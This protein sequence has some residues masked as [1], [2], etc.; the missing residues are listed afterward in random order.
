MR[1]SQGVRSSDKRRSS[2]PAFTS[3]RRTLCSV[4]PAEAA[5]RTVPSAEKTAEAMPS[6]CR[7][8]LDPMR[9]SAPGG[10]GSP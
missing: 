5:A 2:R 10:S 7:K 3:Q 9:A 4:L 6:L 1:S 8:R